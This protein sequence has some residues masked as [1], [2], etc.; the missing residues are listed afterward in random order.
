MITAGVLLWLLAA[1]TERTHQL[2]D[3]RQPDASVAVRRDAGRSDAAARSDMPDA[4]APAN[5]ARP[6]VEAGLTSE[7]C[8]KRACACDDGEDND[9]DGLSDGLDPECTGAFDD[10]ESSFATGRPNK[11]G[12]CRDCYWDDNAGSGNDR[13]RYPAECLTGEAVNGKG[14]CSS[15]QVAAECIAY[16]EQRTP[17]GCDC[18][19]CCEIARDTG[20]H[21]FIALNDSCRLDRLDDLQAC[22]RCT[23]SS[24]CKNACGR[25][26]LCLGK[27]SADLPADCGQTSSGTPSYSCEDGLEVCRNTSQCG[28]DHYCQ[29]GCCLLDLL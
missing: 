21:V 11:Q 22:P 10:D 4:R 2:V 18:F 23:Q 27:T 7:R 1:C 6:P 26:E 20:E 5:D 24:T 3:D 17:N 29:L 15:C 19:G 9:A 16:C 25:C 28:A 14:A 13:C 8:G 12:G